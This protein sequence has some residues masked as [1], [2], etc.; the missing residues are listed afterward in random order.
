MGTTWVL[1]LLSHNQ[2]SS[3]DSFSRIKE[4]TEHT[5]LVFVLKPF[6]FPVNICFL[7]SKDGRGSNPAHPPNHPNSSWFSL[8]PFCPR[9]CEGFLYKLTEAEFTGKPR[10]KLAAGTTLSQADGFFFFLFFFLGPLPQHVDIPSLGVKSDLQLLA[11]ATAVGTRDR[12]SSLTYTTAHG[13]ENA[14]SLTH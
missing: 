2:N 9:G 13:H 12:A 6:L 7:Y 3:K 4:F 1:L 8:A 10:G 5:G 14:R 11:F